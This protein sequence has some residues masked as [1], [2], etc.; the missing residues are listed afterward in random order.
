[1]VLLDAGAHPRHWLRPRQG[2]HGSARD[3]ERAFLLVVRVYTRRG[4][5]ASALSAVTRRRG[6]G[7]S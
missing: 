5:E 3:G 6:T 7:I 4:G 1:V 2:A